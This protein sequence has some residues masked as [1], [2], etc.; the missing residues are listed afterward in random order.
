VTKIPFVS[1][2]LQTKIEE[3]RLKFGFNILIPILLSVCLIR[4]IRHE[5]QVNFIGT[6][7]PTTASSHFLAA[8][9]DVVVCTQTR[10]EIL[11][12]ARP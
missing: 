1:S 8:V 5:I 2:T 11:G 7:P 4:Q 3:C 6:G 9:V 10:V 12:M